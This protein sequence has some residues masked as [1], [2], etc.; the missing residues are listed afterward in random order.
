MTP[1]A[2]AVPAVVREV[3]LTRPVPAIAATRDG[4]RV[5]RAWLLV[6]LFDEPLGLSTMDLPERGLTPDEVSAALSAEYGPRV[7]DRRRAAGDPQAGPT[8]PTDGIPPLADPPF[9][10]SRAAVLADA[11]AITAVVCT[12]DRPEGLRRTVASLVGQHYPRHRVLVVDNAPSDDATRTVV[13]GF[14]G[15]E[16]L[17]EPRPGLS[18]ARNTAV[19]AAP[20]EVLAFTDDDVVADPSWLAEIARALRDHPDAAAVSGI[21]V[22]GELESDAQVWFEQFGG[23]SKGRGFTAEVFSPATAHRQ[24]PLY[25]LP[26]FGT[27]ANMAFR[28]GVIEASA[29]S[30]PRSVPVPRPWVP[31]TPPPSCASCT[32]AAPWCTSRPR[33]CGTTTDPIWPVSSGSSSATAP[34]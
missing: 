34:D 1:T 26:P 13:A 28:P 7:R 2:D 11:P 15:V 31:R 17:R 20:G 19:A 16:Y 32:T 9:L 23:H 5:R 22:P 33:W 30:T 25:P 3:E 21:I 27:G 4:R 6:R 10:A 18:H 29:A 14:D 24:N 8:I 12:R